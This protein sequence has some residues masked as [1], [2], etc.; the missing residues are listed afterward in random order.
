MAI[1]QMIECV[2]CGKTAVEMCAGDGFM[3]WGALQGIAL[4]A[5]INPDLCPTHLS[6]MAEL[7]EGLTL[8]PDVLRERGGL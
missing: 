6:A 8:S 5:E 7:L 3:G 2:V 4:D 1:K